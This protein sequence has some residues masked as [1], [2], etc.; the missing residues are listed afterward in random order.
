VAVRARAPAAFG[1]PDQNVIRRVFM[2]YET[3]QQDERRGGAGMLVVGLLLGAAAGAALALLLAPKPGRE[4]R[5][6]IAKRAKKAREQAN[7]QLAQ[8]RERVGQMVD[9]GREAYDKARGVV[10]RTRDDIKQNVHELVGSG[11]DA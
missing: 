9:K 10:Q 5:E 11:K 4:V 7:D 3:E 1:R 6:D 8:G 2:P